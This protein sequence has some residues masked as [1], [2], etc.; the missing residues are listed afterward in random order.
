VYF[1]QNGELWGDPFDNL[2]TH[3]DRELAIKNRVRV[4]PNPSKDEFV[5]ETEFP[6]QVDIMLYNGIG[7][8][9]YTEKIVLGKNYIVPDLKPGVYFYRI[10]QN[11]QTIQSG[12]ILLK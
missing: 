4:Y 7:N 6:G 12:K 1:E 2:V 5:V 8:P 3:D 11:N 9:V 10:S